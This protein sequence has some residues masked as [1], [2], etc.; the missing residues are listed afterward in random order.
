SGVQYTY[1]LDYRRRTTAVSSSGTSRKNAPY[2]DLSNGFYDAATGVT[3]YFPL[4]TTGLQQDLRYLYNGDQLIS[5]TDNTHKTA[6]FFG[7]DQYDRRTNMSMMG[8]NGLFLAEITTHYDDLSRPVFIYDLQTALARGYDAVGNQRFTKAQIYSSNWKE[9]HLKSAIFNT[10]DA[11]DRIL[12]CGG[13]LSENKIVCTQN[14]GI[15]Y[16]YTDGFR[17]SETYSDSTG[18]HTSAILYTNDGLIQ[19]TGS[20]PAL[21]TNYSYDHA[22]RLTLFKQT[23]PK[24]LK[25]LSSSSG[26]QYQNDDTL[27]ITT[28]KET[29]TKKTNETVSTIPLGRVSGPEL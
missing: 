10:F 28:N 11:A 23:N 6:V 3:S 17:S 5:I 8:Q 20:K 27:F 4:P 24:G 19:Q 18:L 25:P 21:L 7:Y 9:N 15:L 26:F 16:G 1:V 2:Y 13:V 12:I 29:K 14:N 22:G